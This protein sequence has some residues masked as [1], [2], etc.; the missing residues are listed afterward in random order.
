MKPI[1][2]LIISAY[3]CLAAIGNFS[4]LGTTATQALIAYTAPDGNACTIQVS[5][6]AALTPLALDVDPGTF[7]NSNSDLSRPSTAT[8]GLSRRV[9]I[10]QR[11]AQY[12]TAGTYAGVRHFSRSLQA[13]TPYFGM[14]TCPSTGDTLAFAFTTT[15][16]P[17]GQVYGDPWLGDPTHPGDQ[18]WPESVAGLTPESFTDPLTGTNNVR[19]GMRD[20]APTT[21]SPA[22]A[23][24]FNQGQVTP[25][26]S[27]GPWVNPCGMVTGGSGSTT[28]GNS[29]APL[30]L[31]IPMQTYA[32]WTT[33]YASGVSIDQLGVSLAGFVNSANSAF[34]TLAACLSMN[35]G[36]SCASPIYTAIAPQTSGTIAFGQTGASALGACGGA[37]PC[38]LL[39]T[40]PRINSQET[41]A[42]SGTGTITNAG[43]TYYLANSGSN[44]WF[45]LYWIMGGAGTIRVSSNNNACTSPPVTT[46]SAEY[47]IA[48]FTDPTGAGLNGNYI[49]LAAGSTPPT[50]SIY[51]CEQNFT[52]MLWRN[53]APTDG[54]TVTLTSGLLNVSGSYSPG[55]PDN[56]TPTACMNTPVY[57]G[58]FCLWGEMYWINPS[59]QSVVYWGLPVSSDN[60]SGTATITNS[61]FRSPAP[62]AALVDQTQSNLTFYIPGADNCW[63]K[64]NGC[65]VTDTQT[66]GPL[67]LQAVFTPT[68]TPVQPPLPQ[69]SDC[70]IGNATITA[71]D[72]YSTT[73]SVTSPSPWTMKWTNLTPQVT[74]TTCLGVASVG[75]G[76]VQ[77]MSVF[78][79]SLIPSQFDQGGIQWTCNLGIGVSQGT[80]VFACNSYN[81][82]S[83]AWILAFNAGD[84]NPAHAGQSGG[85]QIIGAINTFNTPKGAVADGQTALTGHDLHAIVESGETGWFGIIGNSEPPVTTTSTTIPSS[86]PAKCNTFLSTLSSTADCIAIQMNSYTNQ[87]LASVTSISGTA[88][89]GSV[90]AAC[91]MQSFN[92]GLQGGNATVTLHTANSWTGATTQIVWN[93]TQASAAPTSAYISGCGVNSTV[94]I[95]STVTTVTGYE[96]YFYQNLINF[97]GDPGE[98][99]TTQLGDSACFGSSASSCNWANQ[100]SE[101]M[102]LRIKNYN[103]TP[104]LFVFQRGDYAGAE[105]A[106]SGTTYLSWE[107]WNSYQT[108]VNNGTS[109]TG[110]N[111]WWNP[112]AGCAGAPDPHGDCLREDSNQSGGHQEYRNGG[113]SSTMNIPAWSIP[114]S[115]LGAQ[116]AWPGDWQVIQGYIPGIFSLPPAAETPYAVPGVNYVSINPPFDGIYGMPFASDGQTHPNAPGANAS[117]YEAAQAFDNVCIN[118]ESEAPNFSWIAGQLYRSRPGTVTDPDDFFSVGGQGTPASGDIGAVY[119]NRKILA[120]AASCGSHPLVDVS[121]PASAI[122]SGT[123]SAYTYCVTRVNGECV[124]GSLAG[125]IYVN[126]PGV[127]MTGC[128]GGS[129]HGGVPF[130]IGADICLDN[131][132]RVANTVVQYTLRATDY[133]G[134]YTRSLASA[135]SR[136]RMVDNFENNQLL[137]DNSFLLY[138]QEFLNYDRQNLWMLQMPPYPPLDSVNRG[139]FVP[140]SVSFTP[141]A[142][143]NNTVIDFGYQEYAQSGVPYCTTRLD[144]C[145]ATA[146][147]VPSGY[148]P[149][150][151]ASE[152]PIGITCGSPP[153]TITIPAIAQRELYYR[154]RY[155]N[156]GGGTI[157]VG[158][159][160]IQGVP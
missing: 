53:V 109:G 13:N 64:A 160:Q 107:S 81:G 73:W 96:P 129:Y 57:G 93:G 31:R 108:T 122:G 22:F 40:N 5:T 131:I 10:G 72:A 37:Y 75:C 14:I 4:V 143:T 69:C 36:V 94:T 91:Q 77:Q 48:S 46:T 136:L 21:W 6:S 11:T 120:T 102:T 99:R 76:V 110:V 43:G 16:I 118:G 154:L 139:N 111:A 114:S 8:S 24:A 146:A 51:W 82:D 117:A 123:A 12:A 67:V 115:I 78:D 25:C 113:E 1:A 147:T 132:T 42:H 119:I 55:I 116:N 9:V 126:C 105:L 32:P 41:I 124:A 140:I 7:A 155:Q 134:S 68:A 153:C 128:A 30:V 70:Q 97:K 66:S 103:G 141:P 150:K 159:W 15:N 39:D 106:R 35:G 63:Y 135:T 79:P 45:S 85:P 156:A 133:Y 84:G 34:R 60:G 92:N 23:A 2:L 87:S 144:V 95:A 50:G 89:T 44:D 98:L 137:P 138:S 142:G 74:S 158:P 49:Q 47:R 56:G 86:G 83:P 112:T 90:G 145:E 17:L 38:W 59:T 20:N 3:S 71:S 125:D 33:S 149:F 54:S 130:G 148:Q 80:F 19:I 58:Y 101:L 28:V 127:T 65:A 151:F 52:V 18:P 104:G 88:P 157:Q 61:W 26:D 152:T 62:N 100:T 27:A 29:T 121:G